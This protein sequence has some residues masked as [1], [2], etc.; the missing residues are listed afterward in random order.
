M[1]ETL[2]FKNKEFQQQ[3]DT[4]QK[5]QSYWKKKYEISD[6]DQNESERKEKIKRL[7]KTYERDGYKAEDLFRMIRTCFSLDE[8][9][10]LIQSKTTP[11]QNSL[12]FKS[13][14]G[15]STQMKNDSVI[16]E[17]VIDNQIS[18]E[19]LRNLIKNSYLENYDAMRGILEKFDIE[20]Y[21][22]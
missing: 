8:I 11:L 2:S 6:N 14:D 10:S 13:N 9:N 22:K 15:A 18:E 7:I 12:V 17:A 1:C 21:V 20:G 4:M 16:V 19:R 5:Q 3:V